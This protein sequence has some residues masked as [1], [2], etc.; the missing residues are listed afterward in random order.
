MFLRD[1]ECLWPIPIKCTY[2]SRVWTQCT[3]VEG[4]E[5]EILSSSLFFI[6]AKL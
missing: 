6:C 2:D 3:G 1:I 5:K 4:T